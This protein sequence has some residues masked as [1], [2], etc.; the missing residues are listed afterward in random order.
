MKKGFVILALLMLMLATV[1][2]TGC[3][4]QTCPRVV[5]ASDAEGCMFGYV[6]DD[7]KEI[8]GCIYDKAEPFRANLL[9]AELEKDYDVDVITQNVD[10]LHERAGSSNVLHLPGSLT[11]VTSSADPQNPSS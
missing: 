3:S 6:D 4:K 2:G 11:E 8:T 9:L 10:D 5:S 1:S 7:G